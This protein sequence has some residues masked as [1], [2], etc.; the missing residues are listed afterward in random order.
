MSLRQEIPPELVTLA[1]EF[2]QVAQREYDSWQQDADGMDDELGTGGICDKIAEAIGEI[3][4]EN[5][6]DV[7]PGGQEG[8][9]HSFYIALS[10]GRAFSVDIPYWIYET[11]GGYVWKKKKGV[12][13]S[14]DHVEFIE[15]NYG[16]VCEREAC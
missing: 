6:F 1:P 10:E 15:L 8:D 2:A 11:G 5:G 4:A 3:L 16:E 12:V 14:P 13:F 9:D 7:V